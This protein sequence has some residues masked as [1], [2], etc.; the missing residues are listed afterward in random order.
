MAEGPALVTGASSGIGLSIAH[1]LGEEGYALTV[2]ARRPEKLEGAAEELRGKGYDVEYVAGNLGDEEVIKSVV[3]RHRER[4]GRLDVLVNNAGVGIGAPVGEHQTKRVDM[5]L[6]LNI[7]A[8]I[9]STASAPRCCARR[10][11]ST[12]T[13]SSSTRPRSPASP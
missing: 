11:P 3:A 1:M 4:F 6:D 9:L 7:R 5:Q 12:A 10:A 2:A 13:R 8:I